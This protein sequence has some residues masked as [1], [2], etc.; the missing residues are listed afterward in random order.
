MQQFNITAFSG[1]INQQSITLVNARDLHAALGVK[2]KFADWILRR[3]ED[4][5]FVK[6][7]DFI[8]ADPLLK[9]EK[10]L[11]TRVSGWFGESKIDYHLTLDMAKEL[12]MVE[13]S[14]IGRQ[15]RRYF[16][17]IESE[18]RD[19]IPAWATVQLSET[20]AQLQAAQAQLQAAQTLALRGN[21]FLQRVVR[22]TQAG[23][24][25]N[26]MAK[27]ADCSA[28]KVERAQRLLRAAGL[29]SLSPNPS[30]AG[31]RGGLRLVQL[32]LPHVSV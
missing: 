25:Q 8:I 26:E 1:E 14:E 5:G 20:Q 31:G 30:P 10:Q 29:L 11:N 6:N 27:L 3:I 28:T 18:H 22:Y 15:V 23:L 21:G 24:S 32:S 4:F 16:I 7:E 17:Q 9:N 2:S 13:R 12:A 19:A